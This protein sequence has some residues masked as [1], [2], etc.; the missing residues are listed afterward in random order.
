[1]KYQVICMSFDGEYQKE[2]PEFDTIEQ[3]WDYADDL[4]SKWYF[5]PF[6]FVIK[7]D[8]IVDAGYGAVHLEGMTIAEVSA[9]FKEVSERPEMEGC[10]A[11]EFWF[12]I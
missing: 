12:A 1:M 3:A 6:A 5:Y 2:R 11:E 7:G 9:H 8:K 10:N 4:G